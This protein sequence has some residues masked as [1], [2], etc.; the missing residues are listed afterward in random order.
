LTYY[1]VAV[2]GKNGFAC[3]VE[4]SWRTFRRTFA[5][6]QCSHANKQNPITLAAPV[7]SDTPQ[8]FLATCR[9]IPPSLGIWSSGQKRS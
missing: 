3:M 7:L 9:A 1:E 5:L 6:I 4:R 8:K 2:K